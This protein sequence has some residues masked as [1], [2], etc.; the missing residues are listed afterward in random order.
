MPLISEYFQHIHKLLVAVEK[1]EKETLL[2]A[3]KKV[4]EC[5]QRAGIIQ[6]FGCGHSHLLAE[7]VFYRAGGLVPIKPILIESLM[8]HEGAVRSSQLE[9]ETGY[10]RTFLEKEDIRKED[11]VF[12]ISNSGRNPV[13]ID[14]ALWAK[15]CGA[16]VIGITSLQYSKALPSLHPSGKHLWE[17]V[18]LAI[19]NYS[20]KGDAVLT[21]PHVSVPFAPTST[22]IGAAILHAIFAEAI[23]MIAEHGK[24][25][26]IFVSGNL[27]EGQEHNQKLIEMYRDR[28]QLLR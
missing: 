5:I 13:P 2:I 16:Y 20:V 7:E 10:A 27:Q 17:C 25:T 18:D 23:V 24:E 14:V 15:Q 12:V 26:P 21:H 19:N 1:E 8:L 9:K 11:V 22:I 28:I 6:L 3:A 4:S